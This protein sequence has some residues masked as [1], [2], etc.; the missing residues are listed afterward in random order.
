MPTHSD[1]WGLVVNEAMACGL[2]IVLSRVAGCAADLVREG[3]NG[4]LVPPRNVPA[5]AAAMESLASQ[6]HYSAMMGANSAQHISNYSTEEWC[7]AIARAV[8]AV[9]G[10]AH[11]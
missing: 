9:T 8:G 6:P 7:R 5:L 10:G 3:W 1:P 4:L 2:P 11:D